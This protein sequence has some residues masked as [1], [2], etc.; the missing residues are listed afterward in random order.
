MT[1][2]KNNSILFPIKYISVKFIIS[3]PRNLY[4]EYIY[5]VPVFLN[6]RSPIL[7]VFPKVVS[8]NT[9]STAPQIREEKLLEDALMHRS[10]KEL[11]YDACLFNRHTSAA[12]SDKPIKQERFFFWQHCYLC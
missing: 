1:T 6:K 12:P 10:S 9:D 5:E 11:K 3:F 4:N 8:R 7:Q 2:I